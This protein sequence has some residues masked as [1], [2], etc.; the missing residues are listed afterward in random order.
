ASAQRTV[1]VSQVLS[2]RISD[3]GGLVR[4]L[5]PGASLSRKDMRLLLFRTPRRMA[6]LAHVARRLV[7]WP[8]LPRHVEL[9]DA[10][11]AICRPLGAR[12][13][14]PRLW[15]S[16]DRAARIYAEVD[17]EVL[18]PLPVKMF[19]IPDA[20]TLLVPRSWRGGRAG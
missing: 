4:R 14:V 1:V 20:L 7:N 19:S 9:A 12:T 13:Q 10:S 17:G 5:A 16:E 6:F 15:K 11:E 2:V 18:C 8:W 3:F